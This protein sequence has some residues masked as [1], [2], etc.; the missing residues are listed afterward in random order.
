[1][2]RKTLFLFCLCT[3]IM[4]GAQEYEY[5][6]GFFN[7][8]AMPG[9]C[10]FSRA[11]SSGGSTIK[12]VE[13]KLPVTESVFHTP[14]NALELQYRDIPG[15]EWSAVIFHP[16]KRGMDHFK[17]AAFLSLWMFSDSEITPENKLPQ[18]RFMS[19]DSSLS[20]CFNLPSLKAGEW[21]RALIPLDLLKNATTP[22]NLIA[23][24]FSQ[25][26]AADSE[27]HTLY[28]DD[29]EFLPE[30]P[31]NSISLIP[32]IESAKGYAM[33][34]DISWEKI[35]DSAIHLVK[36]YRAE[37]GKDYHAVGIQQPYINRYEDFTGE[38]GRNYSYRISF[39]NSNY[40]ETSLSSPVMAETKPMSD[41]ELLTMVQEASFRYY[42]EGAEPV[43][44]LA[45]ENIP[46]R[47]NMIATGASGFGMMAL[48]VGAERKFITRQ[49]AADRFYKI[50]T[51]LE[52]AQSYHGVYPHF[53]DG[54]TGKTE[55]FFGKR[56]NGADLV[57]TSFLLEGLLAAR[58]YFSGRD[59]QET[60][61]RQ[62]IT[63]IWEKAEW[64]WFRRFPDSKFL[65][66]HWSP[67]Q[68]WV[69][70]HKLI[71]WNETM[72]VYLLAIA[73][74]THP[75]PAEMYYTGWANQ[76]KTGQKYR[77]NWGG[78][79]EGSKY[80]N[81]YTYFGIKLDVGVSN[82]GP[83]FFTHYSYMGYDPHLI[84]DKYTNYFSNNRNIAKIN[85][86]YCVANPNHFKGY[87]E[88]G[89]GLTA[90]DGPFDYSADEPVPGRDIGKLAPTGAISSFPYTPEE[91]MKALKNYYYNYGRFLW[92][93]YG[94]KD[95]FSLADNWCA[96]IYMGLNQAPMTVMIE[97]YRTGLVWNLFM[98]NP[99]IREGLLFLE[100]K[101]E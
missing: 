3:S 59:E 62:K 85:Y 38:T 26:N 65:Y 15:G 90:S 92:G 39:M 94:F 55:P 74:P 69:I 12:T 95:A 28:V 68:E 81:G 58:Q 87:G 100:T 22:E 75:V 99:E 89:W 47:Q 91:S 36:I 53:I 52:G 67:D 19:R 34:V 77:S 13:G 82:G 42:W 64:D 8:S 48:I 88:D 43:S 78:T 70:N 31:A 10:F 54:P 40:E 44:G 84:T 2:L 24:V 73:S 56:D 32:A 49:E 96:E 41:E 20:A 16:G 98:Q 83:L 101:S 76:E 21:Q 72:V 6:Y 30:G 71:G 80:T 46:G 57:E 25:K 61:I 93:E 29:I 63:G 1:M 4:S 66:W 37:N 18:L 60:Q 45:R 27:T 7:N 17:K 9:S 23:L 79:K 97:N 5:I 86:R 11:K 35:T 14:G 51:F 33:H 50:V